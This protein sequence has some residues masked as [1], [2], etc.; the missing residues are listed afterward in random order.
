MPSQEK[1]IAELHWLLGILQ[2]VDVGLV[3]LDRNMRIQLWNAFM[4]NHSGLAPHKVQNQNLFSLFPELPQQWLVQKIESV[5]LLNNRAFCTWQ[6]RPYLFRFDSYHPI[7]G[8]AEFMYQ[9]LT[10]IPLASVSGEV[11]QVCLILYDVTD[12]AVDHQALQTANKQLEIFGRTDGLTGLYNRSA[13]EEL[14]AAEF[15]R[16]ERNRHGSVLAMFDIDHF[17]NINDSYGHQ[18]GDE[19]I[20]HVAES[21]RQVKREADIAGRY[22]GEEFGLI[23]V[24]TGME[25]AEHFAERLRHAI[26]RS[27]VLCDGHAIRFTISIGLAETGNFVGGYERWIKHADQALYHAKENGRNRVSVFPTSS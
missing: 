18:A 3:V 20:R 11:D 15:K 2:D 23:L 13:W 21:M 6:Q 8:Q 10:I 27:T 24:D 7:T 25:G 5:F 26:E 1:H 16:M 12:S 17:K 14:L 4:E 22:G 9:N 19:V